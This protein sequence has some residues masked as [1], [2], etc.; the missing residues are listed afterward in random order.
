MEGRDGGGTLI[1]TS[2]QVAL[3]RDVKAAIPV[4]SSLSGKITGLRDG[5]R[6]GVGVAIPPAMW[7]TFS[8]CALIPRG[9]RT[10]PSL[11]M[12][13]TCYVWKGEEEER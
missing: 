4:S 8:S 11:E 13:S 5:A 10:L 1:L 3:G 7:T 12:T 6:W 2:A 9:D